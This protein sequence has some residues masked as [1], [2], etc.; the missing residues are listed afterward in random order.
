M[1]VTID[2]GEQT[3][4]WRYRCPH[5]HWNWEVMDSAF[6]CQSCARRTSGDGVFDELHDGVTNEWI[7]HG[8]IS[9]KGT[10]R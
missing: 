10:E 5:G 8:E 4:R 1:G 3:E 2:L 9:F 6:Y 7:G